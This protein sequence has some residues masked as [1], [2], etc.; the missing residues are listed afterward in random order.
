MKPEILKRLTH[1]L[2]AR[3]VKDPEQVA[4][5]QLQNHGILKPGTTELTQK[6]EIRNAMTPAQ[7]AADRAAH[8][9]GNHTPRDYA[10]NPESNR[11]TLKARYKFKPGVLLGIDK[12]GGK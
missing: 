11:A 2:D 5:T 9:S 7:R 1:Q 12:K 3:G 4:L 6:G 10:Y 8:Y